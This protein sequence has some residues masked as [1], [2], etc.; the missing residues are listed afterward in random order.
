MVQIITD[1]AADFEREEYKKMNVLCVPLKVIFGEREFS[2]G[3]DLTKDKFYEM[4]E[5]S[6][7]FPK[8]SQPSPDDF[9][10]VLEKAQS[11]GDE[12]VV[13][14]I[15][16][17]LSG[18]Y[19]SAVIT[20]NS[21]DYNACYVVDSR[22]A[23]IGQRI[24]VEYA[25]SL[26]N[27]GKSAREIADTLN[28]LA[29]RVEVYACI[30]TLAYLHKGG[31]ISG[32]AFAVGT[33]GNVK[34]VLHVTKDGT[35]EMSKKVLGVKRGIDYICQQIETV[36]PDPHF[37]IFILYSKNRRNGELLAIELNKRGIKVSPHFIVNMGAAI[38]SHI[39]TNA[40]GIAFVAE[41]R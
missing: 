25:V 35:I 8:T 39:G 18:T 29:S 21:L 37:P 15:S 38:G 6:K 20:R 2:E 16:S 5:A 40:C 26:R 33:F 7:I 19:Q 1:S 11:D 3:V 36:K 31:R 13:I 41:K 17:A 34:P 32:V 24:L 10:K 4:L 28:A 22:S 27:R 23:S 14:T 30:D 9:S 12:V